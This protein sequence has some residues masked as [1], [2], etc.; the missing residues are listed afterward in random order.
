[1]T[2]LVEVRNSLRQPLNPA[3]GEA[4]IAHGVFGIAVTEIILDE[5]EIVA[6]VR[7][8]EAA[9]VAEHVGMEFSE[10]RRLAGSMDDVVDDG[11]MLTFLIR[12]RAGSGPGVGRERT[13]IMPRAGPKRAQILPSV[14]RPLSL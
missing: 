6:L 7:E 14:Q 11:Q 8:V 1:M 9:G 5:P 2:L 12:V 3:G 13:Q 10:T 4:R